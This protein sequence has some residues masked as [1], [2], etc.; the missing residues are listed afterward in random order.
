MLSRSRQ[1]RLGMLDGQKPATLQVPDRSRPTRRILHP[2]PINLS[3]SAAPST[4]P[5]ARQWARD[6]PHLARHPGNSVEHS[7]W[8]RY[9]PASLVGEDA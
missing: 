4:G 9:F 3:P 2:D 6:A 1:T 7:R 5:T 8:Y